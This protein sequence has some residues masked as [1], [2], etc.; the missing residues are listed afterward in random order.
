LLRLCGSRSSSLRYPLQ[1]PTVI[2]T[3]AR[4]RQTSF[5]IMSCERIR[6]TPGSLTPHGVSAVGL[7]SLSRVY[8][9]WRQDVDGRLS[10]VNH[11]VHMPVPQRVHRVTRREYVQWF[12]S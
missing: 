4:N 5:G 11:S 3:R 6:C 12:A 2:S 9:V 8:L 10:N 1:C 7:H